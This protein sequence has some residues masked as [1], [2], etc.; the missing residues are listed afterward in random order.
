MGF[1]LNVIFD[2][3]NSGITQLILGGDGT[4][5]T[6]GDAVTPRNILDDGS[7]NF[8]S[9]GSVSTHGQGYVSDE[10]YYNN[11]QM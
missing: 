9:L 1:F 6:S 10:V 3:I 7:G 5:F 11:Y 4:I 2:N 8:N